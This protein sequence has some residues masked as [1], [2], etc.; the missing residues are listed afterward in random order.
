MP[1][2]QTKP[3]TSITIKADDLNLGDAPRQAQEGQVESILMMVYV[4]AGIVA[5]V[6]IVIGGVRYTVSGGEANG[7]KAAKDTIL[8]AVVGLV[9]VIAA[10]AITNFIFENVA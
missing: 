1:N 5:V 7:I 10:A 3:S 9:V 2:E 8:Y 6:G 4:L